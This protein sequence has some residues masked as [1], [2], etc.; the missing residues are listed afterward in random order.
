MKK[1]PKDVNTYIATAPKEFRAKL[2]QLRKTIKTT[3]PKAK[4][5]ISYGIPYYSY[6]GRLA[7]F[8]AFKKHIGLYVPTPVIEEHKKE[9]QDY[10]N[11]K[12][13]VRFPIDRPLPIT[14]IKKLIKARMKKNEVKTKK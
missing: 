10:E 11:A 9:L 12:A 3:A 14:I 13:T 8:A 5:T 2:T 7:Y 6:N 1:H 4:E